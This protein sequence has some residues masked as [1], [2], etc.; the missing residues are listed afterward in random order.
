MRA[1]PC[2]ADDARTA[3]KVRGGNL[4]ATVEEGAAIGH[5]Y[6]TLWNQK[7][8]GFTLH[9]FSDD[10]SSLTTEYI[11]YQGS[12]IHSFTVKKADRKRS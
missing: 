2:A 12:T 4:T 5:Q 11:D 7:V 6:R 1:T 8:A 3:L 10:Y 9:T